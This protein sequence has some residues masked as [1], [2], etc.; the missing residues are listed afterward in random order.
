MSKA[1]PILHTSR[2]LFIGVE[3]AA[4]GSESYELS[5]GK[6]RE[7]ECVLPYSGS[8]LCNT[9]GRH[10]VDTGSVENQRLRVAPASDV[11]SSSGRPLHI[12]IVPC[13]LKFVEQT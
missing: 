11:H 8:R 13:C 6:I 9:A 10:F 4:K 2:S 1:A 12:V 7:A 3:G 5:P